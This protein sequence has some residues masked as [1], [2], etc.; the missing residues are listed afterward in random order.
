MLRLGDSKPV[1]VRRRTFTGGVRATVTPA[2]HG[3][4]VTRASDSDG[5]F[6][7]TVTSESEVA[8]FKLVAE[9]PASGPG[10]SDSVTLGK[11]HVTV[12]GPD[13]PGHRVRLGPRRPRQS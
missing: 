3:H 5:A 6:A 13:W 2:A 8:E 7:G 12:G 10:V 9:P 4:A 1:R 11:N